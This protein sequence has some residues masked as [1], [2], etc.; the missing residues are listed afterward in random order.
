MRTH[1][2]DWWWVTYRYLNDFLFL[3]RSKRSYFKIPTFEQFSKY[4]LSSFGINW[5]VFCRILAHIR[6]Y[7]INFWSKLQICRKFQ[8]LPPK[9]YFTIILIKKMF[10]QQRYSNMYHLQNRALRLHTHIIFL[11]LRNVIIIFFSLPSEL[12]YYESNKRDAMW[13]RRNE[14]RKEN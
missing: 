14:I 7:L 2:F 10:L 1:F 6:S 12:I 11:W 8:P 13:G 9:K 3:N 5:I 4:K